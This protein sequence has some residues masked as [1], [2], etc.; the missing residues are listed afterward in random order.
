MSQVSEVKELPQGRF[1]VAMSDADWEDGEAAG[2]ARDHENQ[3]HPHRHQTHGAEQSRSAE[4]SKRGGVGEKAVCVFLGVPFAGKGT[5]GEVDVAGRYEVKS[6]RHYN[7][8]LN[9]KIQGVYGKGDDSQSLYI[10][11][12]VNDESR[13]VSLIGWMYGYE[14]MV[15]DNWGDHFRNGRP[16][17]RVSAEYLHPI[18]T[19]P[20]LQCHSN[21]PSPSPS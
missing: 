4:Y 3:R 14:A 2:L 21:L 8:L 13:E 20:G 19:L 11:T 10:A 7:L 9:K 17:W 15:D 16:C 1:L 12:T 5:L 18:T 6:S